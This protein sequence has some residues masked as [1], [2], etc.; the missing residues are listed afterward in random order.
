MEKYDDYLAFNL[1]EG[2]CL[3]DEG[4]N[5]NGDPIY[6]IKAEKYINDN[7]E[8]SY[9]YSVLVH[10]ESVEYSPFAEGWNGNGFTLGGNLDAF[11]SVDYNE[12]NV[13]IFTVNVYTVNIWIKKDN[14]IYGLLG[15]RAFKPGDDE[16]F[17]RWV[18]FLNNVLASVNLDG[19][20]G[21]FENLTPERL[22]SEKI[23]LEDTAA[24]NGD[25]PTAKP[26]EGQH[27]HLDFL[28]RTRAGLSFLGGLVS[29]NQTGTEYSFESIA[30]MADR[31]DDTELSSIYTT[32]AEADK[33]EF[34]LVET[35]HDMAELFRV[36]VNYHDPFHDREQEIL[37]GLI[38]RAAMYNTFRSF[39]WTLQAYCEKE[40]LQ[41]VDLDFDTIKSLVEFIGDRE[42]LNY[43]AD[44]YSPAI[45]S[46]DDIHDYFIPDSVPEWLRRRLLEIVNSN[47]E[48]DIYVSDIRSLDSL[49]K[50]LDYMYPAIKAIYDELE[51][52][53]NTK[54][55]LV[56]GVAD[57]LYAWCSMTYAAR[58]PIFT[59]DG[60]MN[61][62]WEHPDNQ[63]DWE[64]NW[65]IQHLEDGIKE[66]K[67][68]IEQ[69]R[70]N[71][72]KNVPITF[73]GKT[74]VFSG[75]N[76]LDEWL[77]ILKK[78]TDLGGVERSAVSGKTDYLVCNPMYAGD[79]KVRHALEQRIKGKD[80][81][82]VLLDDFLKA[83]NIYVKTPEEQL[84]ELKASKEKKP[85]E[86]RIKEVKRTNV[87]KT[88]KTEKTE[89]FTYNEHLQ[90]K[91]PDY[92]LDIPDGF[93]I[94]KDE[95]GRDFIAYQPNEK[96]P[97]SY[98]ESNFVIF[99][100][101][102]IENET[103]AQLRTPAEF[104]AFCII[105][106]KA[107][108]MFSTESKMVT[109]DRHDLPGSISIGYDTGV[110]HVNAAFGI[111][112]HVQMMRLQINSVSRINK[113]SYEKA[114]E[115]IFEHMKSLK[116]VK[117]L[118]NLDAEEFIGMNPDDEKAS[119]WIA[120]VGEYANHLSLARNI[121]QNSL[122]GT[123]Q[124]QQNMGNADLQQF[125]K[126]IK[127]MLNSMSQYFETELKKA[128]LVYTLKRAQFPGSSKL[129]DMKEAVKSL[130]EL[131]TQYVVLDE[132]EI[133]AE[134]EFA[135]TV[136]SGFNR[137]TFDAID[138]ILN[139]GDDTYNKS[140]IDALKKA[141]VENESFIKAAEAYER[142]IKEEEKLRKEKEEA[143][144]KRR[145]E[146]EARRKIEEAE[147]RH[148]EAEEAKK[149]AEEDEKNKIENAKAHIEKVISDCNAKVDEF[150]KELD[151]A[152]E[153]HMSD[154]RESIPSKLEEL[155]KQKSEKEAYL[156]TIGLFNFSE[157]KGVK[158]AIAQIDND[159]KQLKDPQFIIN[160]RTSIKEIYDKELNNYSA[161]VKKHL[162]SR[163]PAR[164]LN[165]VEFLFKCSNKEI[166]SSIIDVL[167]NTNNM[168]W[169]KKT[170]KVIK[171]KL[172]YVL[173]K[174]KKNMS[175]PE[176][177]NKL[178]EAMS[179]TKT[180]CLLGE[181][182]DEGK[183]GRTYEKRVAYYYLLD[184]PNNVLDQLSSE[185]SIPDYFEVE[186][187][188]REGYPEPPKVEDIQ[189]T[190]RETV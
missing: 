38:H 132:E 184:S 179:V 165:L 158:D 133:K 65:R 166:E 25:I 121:W 52:T 137:S 28:N 69:N 11:V 187:Y 4:T 100:G 74:F 61:N 84:A 27:T 7:G 55:A 103:F 153:K 182:V 180:T 144:Q 104:A 45:C 126:D 2:Y 105:L 164:F 19:T 141:K 72:S 90:A 83:I 20:K 67:R 10:T 58:E 62:F 96:D 18:D 102:R 85:A 124:A 131:A 60:P 186:K 120:C 178:G 75:V 68:W 50:E 149:K 175:V 43:V 51:A 63:E 30:E 161:K 14:H 113:T 162:E 136:E 183:V 64:L 152:L 150:S 163:F 157:K 5:D 147:R 142:R 1:P 155:N 93:V 173:A 95:E 49:R 17:K 108:E 53:R 112:D 190:D 101:N 39:A 128:N 48:N 33:G 36:D 57:I 159:I 129:K 34:D 54:E 16:E 146:E 138:Q 13:M 156:S 114:A 80:V 185:I 81:K 78:L 35:A 122:V 170:N 37:N 174:A 32:I 118:K 167:E 154:F 177:I 119:E 6:S 151:M 160:E 76:G 15:N 79:S 23:D 40:G 181:L 168:S 91:G 47:A 26:L 87:K 3:V 130:A 143:E 89:M 148:R 116:P 42:G 109:V 41:P 99:A 134:S 29:I 117:L 189:I 97:E 66:G 73:N 9:N 98:L 31:I 8:E 12:M 169:T 70:N 56:D 44:S 22:A 172:L 86:K 145:A 140:A 21:D 59:E 82:I 71:I 171:V 106:G 176:I 188:A 24:M 46:G 125:K 111:G 88:E 123:F 115:T 110:L 135:K 94:K 92:I 139:S 107:S 127:E 77:D